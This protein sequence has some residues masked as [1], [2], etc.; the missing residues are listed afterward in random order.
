M[1]KKAI[2]L[3]RANHNALPFQDYISSIH[4]SFRTSGESHWDQ[5]VA[6]G[7]KLA[8]LILSLAPWSS[9]SQRCRRLEVSLCRL[10]I[11]HTR[12]THGHLMALDV[13]PICNHYQVRLSISH[14]LGE[15]PTYSV[16]CNRVYPS[17]T[18]APP[19]ECL[20]FLLS[21][22]PTFSSSTLHF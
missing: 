4:R 18:S 22:S 5:C 21:E 17:L 10:C 13:L 20:S 9:Y 2:Q 16:P 12:L 3:P 19:R 7:N 11:G 6:D 8:Q 14:I 15:C 1:A